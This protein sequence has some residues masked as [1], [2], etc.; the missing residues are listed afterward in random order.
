MDFFDIKPIT[1]KRLD[2][3]NKVGLIR[4]YRINS[5]S[6]YYLSIIIKISK[7]YKL[8]LFKANS[9]IYLDLRYVVKLDITNKTLASLLKYLRGLVLI[10]I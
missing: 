9:L 6:C 2:I 10:I 5:N 7:L 3:F 1:L 4:G 8:W